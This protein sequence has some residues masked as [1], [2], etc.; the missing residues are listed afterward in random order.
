MTLYCW[1]KDNGYGGTIYDSKAVLRVQ[2][3][4]FQTNQA[5]G[6]SQ[7]KLSRE[8]SAGTYY[9]KI[10]DNGGRGI[11]SFDFKFIIQAEKQIKLSKG[12]L[13]S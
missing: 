5:T 4:K 7:A 2:D 6:W 11:Q 8:L 9:L 10:D 12:T 3:L 13:K 1:Y